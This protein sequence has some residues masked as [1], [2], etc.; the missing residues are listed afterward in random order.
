MTIFVPLNKWS[1]ATNN[2]MNFSPIFFMILSATDSTS[3]P[4]WGPPAVMAARLS[5]MMR[6]AMTRWWGTPIMR[7][8]RLRLLPSGRYS[9]RI[10]WSVITD[11]L[12]SLRSGLR[13]RG[14]RHHAAVSGTI[15]LT[16][17]IEHGQWDSHQ[18]WH[19][20]GD[21]GHSHSC[22][23]LGWSPATIIGTSY[24]GS[25]VARSILST[26][27]RTRLTLALFPCSPTSDTSSQCYIARV[28]L[29][30]LS[31]VY[32]FNF[33]HIICADLGKNVCLKWSRRIQYSQLKS[34]IEAT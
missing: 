25:G 7:H 5:R 13:C 10:S 1:F 8:P 32:T 22:P 33:P 30:T 21:N 3:S 27:Q 17:E 31:P 14:S 28:S 18:T 29:F 2:K 19:H 6:V 24:S 15:T 20:Q 4:G 23:H 16:L 26:C 34:C 11:P 12:G 9:N